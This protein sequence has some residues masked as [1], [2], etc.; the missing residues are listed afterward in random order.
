M[1]NVPHVVIVFEVYFISKGKL[2]SIQHNS[3]CSR[4]RRRMILWPCDSKTGSL[5]GMRH[6]ASTI[7]VGKIKVLS[8]SIDNDLIAISSNASRY[9]GRPSKYI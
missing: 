7:C 9:V 3:E 1:L 5:V 6:N 4:K 2:L 8:V